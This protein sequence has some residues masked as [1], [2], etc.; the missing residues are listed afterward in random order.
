[1]GIVSSVSTIPRSSWMPASA[2]RMRRGPS[3]WNGLVTQ[4]T[5]SAPS[6]L[7][8]AAT[9]G[10]APVPVPPPIP[11]VM[12]T[13]SAP[14]S[15]WWRSS[16]SSLAARRPTSGSEP[17]PSPPVSLVPSWILI[18]AG[19]AR[20]AWASV[21]AT[22]NV[23]PVKR[24]LIIRFTAFDPPPPSPTTRIFAASSR[25]SSSS[26]KMS[27]SRIVA[28]P[29]FGRRSPPAGSCFRLRRPRPI[30]RSPG[31]T[32]ARG[33]RSGPPRASLRPARAAGP[34]PPPADGPGG[35]R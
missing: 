35:R 1:M 30:R 25:S 29:S 10:A 3:N 2:W 8:I 12:K 9:T 13:M 23:T 7:A 20:S 32:R 14:V 26:R 27:S 16:R 15:V 17:A 5:V 34:P 4:A 19:D 6:S 22:A 33:A 11:A 21:F 28:S 24:E 31:A 18:A